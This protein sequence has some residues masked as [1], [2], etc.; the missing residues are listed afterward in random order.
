MNTPTGI[1]VSAKLLPAINETI[2][3][4]DLI[5]MLVHPGAER[6]T[7]EDHWARLQCEL[8]GEVNFLDRRGDVESQGEF[9][10][11][12][13]NVRNSRHR[14]TKPTFILYNFAQRFMQM[15]MESDISFHYFPG[16]GQVN[17][18]L[19]KL[20]A[21]DPVHGP[22]VLELPRPDT[23]TYRADNGSVQPRLQIAISGDRAQDGKSTLAVELREFLRER[24]PDVVVE[25]Y[26][27]ENNLDEWEKASAD[28]RTINAS[29]IQIL[30]IN[31]RAKSQG[32]L[33][34]MHVRH[35]PINQK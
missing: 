2:G 17:L 5:V 7:V 33:T 35:Y 23:R 10:Q 24:Y 19:G 12:I 6:V 28:R 31:E 30:D 18:Q 8:E 21:R 32:K 11:W 13:G 3:Q 4:T 9:L 22:K 27:S 20:R 29:V 14:R 34:G 26:S 16:S 25:H 1:Q 15:E